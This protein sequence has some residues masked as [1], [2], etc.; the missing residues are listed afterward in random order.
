MSAFVENLP[1]DKI[2]GICKKYHVNELSVFGSVLREDFREDSDVD[3]LVEFKKDA[4]IGLIK[5]IKLKN[6]LTDLIGV[7]VDLVQKGG[8]RDSLRDTIINSSRLIYA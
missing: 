1:M 6:E 4:K 2:G 5:Y 7:E 8:L 3:M